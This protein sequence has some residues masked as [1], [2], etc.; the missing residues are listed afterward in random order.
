[1][2]GKPRYLSTNVGVGADARL[3]CVQR[4]QNIRTGK[5]S[6]MLIVS[7]FPALNPSLDEP[8]GAGSLFVLNRGTVYVVT[9]DDQDIALSQIVITLDGEP[10]AQDAEVW[11]EREGERSH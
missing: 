10:L 2:A 9:N 5:D 1:M 11:F 7:G 4:R 3:C 6:L 8:L